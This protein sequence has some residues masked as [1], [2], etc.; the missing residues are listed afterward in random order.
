MLDELL[1]APQGQT[2]DDLQRWAHGRLRE[3]IEDA[4]PGIAS[5]SQN[6]VI[7]AIELTRAAR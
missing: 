6:V 1:P 2:D 5:P 7:R 3:L 4:L